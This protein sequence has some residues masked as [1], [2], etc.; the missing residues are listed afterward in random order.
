MRVPAPEGLFLSW[1]INYSLRD[2][3]QNFTLFPESISGNLLIRLLVACVLGGAIGFERDI[4]GRAAG[5]RTNMLVSMGAALFMLLSVA[6]AQIYSPGS[7]STG[8]RIDPSRIA[9]QI[10]KLFARTM[11]VSCHDR[12]CRDIGLCLLDPGIPVG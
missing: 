3:L 8:L 7:E 9:A 2:M 10:V 12:L 11:L 1:K 6:I 4:H 5:L